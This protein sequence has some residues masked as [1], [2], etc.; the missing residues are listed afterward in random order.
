MHFAEHARELSFSQ[1]KAQ[2]INIIGASPEVEALYTWKGSD[3]LVTRGQPLNGCSS[4]PTGVLKLQPG[5]QLHALIQLYP[6]GTIS[7][8]ALN[9]DWQLV[10]MGTS[11]GFVLYD[12]CHMKELLVRCTLDPLALL[13]PNDSGHAAGTTISRRKSLKKSLRESFRKLRR[14][15]S[16]KPNAN[17]AKLN[18]GTGAAIASMNNPTNKMQSMRLDTDMDDM[19]DHRP[20]ERQVESRE[21][22]SDDIPPSVIRYIYFVRTFITN[23]QQMTNSMWVGT[24]TGII[25]IYALQFLLNS[26]TV[27]QP[28]HQIQVNFGRR[29]F[30]CKKYF[31]NYNKNQSIF[32]WV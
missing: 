4:N 26:A 3:P 13:S 7:A 8:L 25:Y 6:P 12:Y 11:N 30:C 2:R 28:Q 21:F 23:G 5:F 16:Q 32:V 18:L 27:I 19:N 29:C 1:I 17:K 22:K 31:K 9:A 24:N 14:G 20:I 15:R 10:G